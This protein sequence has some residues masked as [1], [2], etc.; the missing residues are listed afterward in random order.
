MW[1]DPGAAQLAAARRAW[2]VR[3]R[4]RLAEELRDR[5]FDLAWAALREREEAV[6][7]LDELSRARFVLRRLYPEMA[8]ARLDEVM[9][10]LAAARSRGTWPGFVPPESFV[11]AGGR[12]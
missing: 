9:D 11:R 8:E 7:R 1:P 4:L 12:P 6:G 2:T 3:E 10:Q 5:A